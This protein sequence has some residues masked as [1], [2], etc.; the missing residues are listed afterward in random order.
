MDSGGSLMRSLFHIRDQIEQT[1]KTNI[2]AQFYLSKHA[3]SHMKR[4]STIIN[5][6]SVNHF[7][8]HPG[9]LDYTSTKGAIIAFTRSLAQ[10]LA[11]EGIRVNAVAPG[12]YKQQ[13]AFSPTIMLASRWDEVVK[14][15][16]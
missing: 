15:E 9:L 7:M 1:F 14:V 16:S 6:S 10:Q 12:T 5:T 8:G 3:L 2:F 4:G 11:E 13:L